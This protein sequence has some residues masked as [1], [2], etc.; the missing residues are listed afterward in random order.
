M[1]R[2]NLFGIGDL[3]SL[4]IIFAAL[5]GASV[6]SAGQAAGSSQSAV[7]AAPA[8]S[9]PQKQARNAP[10]PGFAA[11]NGQTVV[12][13]EI[14]GVNAELLAPLK[15]QL[16]QKTGKPLDPDLVR[17]S[18][19]RLYASGRFDTMVIEGERV[20]GGVKL[21]F[22]GEPRYFVGR[23]AVKGIKDER[24][25]G[26][27]VAATKLN[28]GDAYAEAEGKRGIG[29]ILQS[30]ETS[31]YH[32]AKVTETET[33]DQQHALVTITYAVEAGP[34]A[35]I[36]DVDARGDVDMSPDKFR[37]VSKLKR[38]RKVS[39]DTTRT[40]L[41]KLKTHYEK[42]DHL[43][44]KVTL[45]KDQY[46]QPANAMDYGFDVQRGPEIAVTVDGAKVRKGK[47]RN[48]V[49]VY[50]EGAVDEDL[51][52]EGSRNLRNYFQEHGYFD[53][54]VTH[55]TRT[56]NGHTTIVY[57]VDRGARHRVASVQ[58]K[59]NKY[60]DSDTIRER[61]NV[62]RADF[63]LR[64][65]RFSE[66]MVQHDVD[67][68]TNLY[69]SNGFRDV[70]VTSEVDDA[71]RRGETETR[72]K[73]VNIRVIYTVQENKQSKFGTV[74]F[75]GVEQVSEEDLKKLINTSPNQPYSL[76]NLSGDR[77]ALLNY[78]EAHGFAEARVE[79]AQTERKDDPQMVDI[80]FK[81]TEGLQVFVNSVIL[82]GLH[83]TRESVV[84][85]QIQVH[86]GEPLD[87]TALYETQ[88]RLYDLALFNEVDI[89]TE[90]PE[91]QSPKKNVLLNV[92]EARRYNF[93]YGFGI[94]AQTGNP[95]QGCPSVATLLQL[96]IDPSTYH[97]S[98]DGK[99]G[100]SALVG[101]DLTRIN[102]RGK[103]E[104]IT[105]HTLYGSLE[106]AATLI[107]TDPHFR[108]N[109]NLSFSISG[110]YTDNQDVTTFAASRLEGNVQL[111]QVLGRAANDHPIDTL[112]YRFAYR[113]VKVDPNTIQ[114][115]ADEIPLLSQPARVGG[116]GATFIRDTRDNPLDSHRGNFIT[117]QTFLSSSIFASQADFIRFDGTWSS[118][119]AFGKRKWV[120]AR[121]TRFGA[122][123]TYGGLD[124]RTI[125]LPE[126]LFAGGS[127]SHRGFAINQA[128]P[129]DTQTGYPLGGQGAFVNSTELRTPSAQLPLVGNNLSFVLFHDVGN[130]FQTPGE[131]FSSM[132]QWTQPDRDSCR[133]LATNGGTCNFNY[134]SHAVGLGLRYA[135]PIGPIR[136]DLS[137][138]LNPPTYPVLIDPFQGPHV[139]QLSHFN[140]FFSIGQSF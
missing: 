38:N 52:N 99:T 76:V 20:P 112:I 116:P 101:F 67:A 90:N 40:A 72:L 124:Y 58:V 87:Q 129:R 122:E 13:L 35:R 19:R 55:D 85:R 2:S 61:L 138:N 8:A 54:Q 23:V 49:P 6:S 59:G 113:R 117:A 26:Q 106:K 48:L 108:N 12:A 65:G 71:D 47:L 60:F 119:Y 45:D 84:Q 24:L 68:I 53:A 28:L 25:S 100:A 15:A 78:Y 39:Q 92:T 69:Q 18:L 89:A 133:N 114:V 132:F 16:P 95:T 137:D 44:A 96:G 80:T 102:F 97:C 130:V 118:Y 5:L 9:S 37:R 62:T 31:G 125:P 98:P 4:F 136:V 104:T 82:H 56:E 123:S 33:R 75:S 135:T 36:G 3:R 10:L 50:V 29:L 34:V 120:I 88:R 27:L 103:D 128:G 1:L 115:A 93:T 51:L 139:G 140:F 79:V 94:Q 83:Y 66:A 109:P 131:V 86:A 30:L 43:E 127:T 111:Q 7:T 107:Y 91:G 57:K 17:E 74:N 126:R 70:K 21:I 77:E 42:N 32:Q 110:G 134:M 11:Y 22:T 81:E 73:A 46:D 63:L 64:Y 121:S 105:L 14:R 41:S